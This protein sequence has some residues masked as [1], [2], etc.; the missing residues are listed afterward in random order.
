MFLEREKSIK[1][2]CFLALLLGSFVFVLNGCGLD[3]S[4]RGN[5]K[6][7]DMEL[8]TADSIKK[9]DIS[10]VSATLNIAA[11]K[12]DKVTYSIDENLKD[13]LSIEVKDG[14]LKISPNEK[15][16]KLGYDNKIVFNV[17]TDMLEEIYIYGD[18]EVNGEGTFI[19]G[20]FTTRIEGASKVNLDLSAK[21]TILNVYGATDV[22]LSGETVELNI[23]SE[24]ATNIKAREFL[25]QDVSIDFNGVCT[26]E[27]Y[28][29]NKLN[30][31]GQGISTIKY[32]GNAELTG[33]ENGINSIKK[34]D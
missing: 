31:S 22:N 18:V 28:A 11:E 25:A 19:S 29:D 24:G 34:G 12:N 21:S 2:I 8:S 9:I 16:K 7:T 15:G 4:I 30:V 1:K 17:G 10:E 27:V 23:K 13:L 33:N 20:T 32:W 3:D 26:I 5:G 6:M 14:V